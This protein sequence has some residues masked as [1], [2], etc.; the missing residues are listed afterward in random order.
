MNGFEITPIHTHKIIQLNNLSGNRAIKADFGNILYQRHHLVRINFDLADTFPDILQN[1]NPDRIRDQYHYLVVAT[2]WLEAPGLNHLIPVIPPSPKT[3][4]DEKNNDKIEI[5]EGNLSDEPVKKSAYEHPTPFVSFLFG[6]DSSVSGVV[7]GDNNQIRYYPI[8]KSSKLLGKVVGPQ[9]LWIHFNLNKMEIIYSLEKIFK[10]EASVKFSDISVEHPELLTITVRRIPI[11]VNA[12]KRLG[13]IALEPWSESFIHETLL[14]SPLQMTCLGLANNYNDSLIKR[15]MNISS[16]SRSNFKLGSEK[17]GQKATNPEPK[18]SST[19]FGW[20]SINS[21][22]NS[23][24]SQKGYQ[25]D[26]IKNQCNS[27]HSDCQG[28]E[29]I[30][31]TG[32]LVGQ[33]KADGIEISQRYL[34]TKKPSL[35]VYENSWK[36]LLLLVIV[37]ILIIILIYYLSHTRAFGF[38]I[39]F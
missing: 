37:T 31:L 32:P 22:D 14:G 21:S 20:T 25:D 27:L 35:R 34:Y 18:Q 15:P 2:F 30:N 39:V 16:E 33:T 6:T 11:G 36:F 1:V 3:I 12:N 38:E 10:K 4:R 19:I 5:I 13:K 8:E 29:K 17:F 26:R 7:A 28:I 9:T 23:S 24:N